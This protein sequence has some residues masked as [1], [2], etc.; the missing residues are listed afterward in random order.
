ME[1]V[2]EE[3]LKR[4]IDLAY[5]G[6][7]RES[8]KLFARI[9]RD[10]PE[11][12][13]AWIYL[14]AL[15]DTIGK[16]VYCYQKAIIINPLDGQTRKLLASAEAELQKLKEYQFACQEIMSHFPE[17]SKA[18]DLSLLLEEPRSVRVTLLGRIKLMM[19]EINRELLK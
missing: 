9:V 7:K 19:D 16:R 5:S 18:R 1:K 8:Y 13:L 3:T 6:D 15:V 2:N 10:D 11:N 4:A 12:A 17:N 14:G